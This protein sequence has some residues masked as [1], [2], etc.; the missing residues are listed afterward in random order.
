MI[1]SEIIALKDAHFDCRI[2][3]WLCGACRLYVSSSS[4]WPWAHVAHWHCVCIHVDT[5]MWP[6][7]LYV[8]IH[9]Q[10]DM[11]SQYVYLYMCILSCRVHLTFRA[12]A[13]ALMSQRQTRYRNKVVTP[14][15]VYKY[16]RRI[17]TY[18]SN[19]KV[20]PK[21][22]SLWN[23]LFFSLSFGATLWV[24]KLGAWQRLESSCPI[25][26]SWCHNHFLYCQITN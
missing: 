7:W 16:G 4:L 9:A 6:D 1:R 13:C 21:Y 18:C 23:L 5:V 2:R 25:M 3:V 15:T 10:S 26:M 20:K 8:W 19:A 17:P 22:V 11:L 14:W 24:V 12:D